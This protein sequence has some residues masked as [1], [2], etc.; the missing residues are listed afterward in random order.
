[1][2]RC[3]DCD[4]EYKIKPDYCECGNDKFIER[5]DKPEIK[6]L[7]DI[8]DEP[9]HH[10]KTSSGDIVS[11]AIFVICLI[12]AII[13]WL[14]PSKPTDKTPSEQNK[15]ET[16]V[17]DIPSIDKIWNDA[18]P[19]QIQQ[20]EKIETPVEKFIESVE[21][22]VAPTPVKV[23]KKPQQTLTTSKSKQT[24]A[25]QV[26][27]QAK[28]QTTT[29]KTTTQAPQQKTK[30][31][32][33]ATTTSKPQAQAQTQ[34]QTQQVKKVEQS[35]Q[36]QVKSQTPAKPKMEAKAFQTYKNGIRLELMS[37]LD[38]V[39]IKGSGTCEVKFSVDSTG[40]LIN[41]NFVYQ[42][43]NKSMD[44]QIYLM[45]MRLP[46]YRVPPANYNDEVIKI[47]F[48]VDN[49]AYEVSFID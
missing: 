4:A 15:I 14:I 13:P 8:D 7:R 30:Q 26:K 18:P 5:E 38:L 12:L 20:P 24:Q 44:D 35:Q 6:P 39:K 43:G 48:T 16:P 28:Q 19:R 37:R 1:M 27:K 21:K 47:K 45:L 11:I 33:K 25:Q 23:E 46:S 17:K 40:K 9:Q 32:T 3:T 49:G 41:R 2:F 22:I 42:S 31:E 10:K 36:T 29:S 34:Q